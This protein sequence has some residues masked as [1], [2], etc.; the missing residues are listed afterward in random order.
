MIT[1]SA[2]L[3]ANEQI[4]ARIAAGEDIVHLAFGEAGLP[5]HP[6]LADCLNRSA[7]RTDYPAV[8]GDE[9]ARIAAAGYFERR[10]LPTDAAQ[11]VFAPGSKALLYAVLLAVPGD[12]VLPQPSWVSYAAQAALA[13]RDTLLV[14]IPEHTGGV[15]DPELL[16]DALDRAERAGRRVGSLILTRP[17]NPTGTIADD[18]TVK[19]VCEVA[20][21]HDL[22]VVSDEIYADLCHDA[23]AAYPTSAATLLPDRAVVT[24]GLSKR[25]A[26]GGWRVGVARIPDGLLR[27]GES[28]ARNERLGERDQ[29]LRAGLTDQLTAI[30]SE[31]WSSMAAPM[32]DVARYAFDEPEELTGYIDQAR[33]LHASVA[34]AMWQVWTDA[35]ALCRRPQ[36]GFYLYPDLGPFAQRL[37]DR[38]ISTSPDLA[39]ALL[40]V[41]QVGV[42]P[43]TAFGDEPDRLTARV[44]TSLLYGITTEQRREA[45]ASEAPV[46]LPWIR[47]SLERVRDGLTRLLDTA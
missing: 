6:A 21:S 16:A 34:H 5:V 29:G 27:S 28:R 41:A 42:L 2:T 39:A 12:V 45:L 33:S 35:G 15:P 3:A 9:A 23:D 13:G 17:D 18:D 1:H 43:G 22:V 47:K 31:I 14:P 46:E 19:R 30:G 10:G 11:V 38:G 26:L 25:L 36:G 24:T 40:D 8:V 44:A 20:A 37:A 32:Q 4:R 7:H